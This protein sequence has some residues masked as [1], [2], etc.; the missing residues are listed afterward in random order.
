MKITRKLN[1][2]SAHQ[3]L[4]DRTQS[5][6]LPL[7]FNSFL[8][9]WYRQ[10]FPLYFVSHDIII[11]FKVIIVININSRHLP[12][13]CINNH[14]NN[15]FPSATNTAIYRNRSASQN[16]FDV[17]N[18]IGSVQLAALLWAPPALRGVLCL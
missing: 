3:I 6:D 7:L 13:L 17:P 16:D 1:N 18:I 10:S 15:I 8:L 12:L 11:I 4:V 2:Y 9:H 5:I 14:Q